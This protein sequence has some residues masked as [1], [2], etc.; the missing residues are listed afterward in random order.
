M[1][2]M[3]MK[4]KKK[5]RRRITLQTTIQQEGQ[6]GMSDSQV[7]AKLYIARPSLLKIPVLYVHQTVSNIAHSFVHWKWCNEVAGQGTV[8]STSQRCITANSQWHAKTLDVL[9]F[10]L[11]LC[12]FHQMKLHIQSVLCHEMIQISHVPPKIRGIL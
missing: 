7:D 10:F 5:M 3:M 1:M 6:V 9:L 4:M 8:T 11:H 12:F 2:T